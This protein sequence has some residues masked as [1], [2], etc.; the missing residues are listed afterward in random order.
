VKLRDGT[1]VSCHALLVA[2]GLS[3]K[4]LEIPGAEELL[5]AG[6]YYGAA[7]TEAQLCAGE[8]VFVV[9]GANSAGQAA[10][11]FAQYARSVTMVVRAESLEKGMSQYLIEQIRAIPNIC[12]E[13]Q[14]EVVAVHG[15]AH[16]ESVTV[17]HRATGYQRTVPTVALFIFIGAVPCT[18]WLQGVLPMDDRGFLLT[19]PFLPKEGNTVKGW[20]EE[21]DPFLF[22]SVIPGI[23][24]AGDIRHASIKRVASA[25]GEGSI[26]VQMVHQYLSKVA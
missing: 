6:V 11:Y 18:G 19:G 26:T 7:M 24:A 22:E 3:W 4:K 16:L 13:T 23:F 17:L 20:K 12:V 9:G 2:S 15:N 14:A 1:E 21:R 5:E 8:D 10:V 25:V